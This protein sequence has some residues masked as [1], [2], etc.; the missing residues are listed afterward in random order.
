MDVVDDRESVEAERLL[1]SSEL[2]EAEESEEA[3][4]PI[5]IVKYKRWS[6]GEGEEENDQEW[7]DHM[8]VNHRVREKESQIE[9]ESRWR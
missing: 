1:E 5:A 8:Q 2:D 9:S 7:C 3:R 4:D 6:R